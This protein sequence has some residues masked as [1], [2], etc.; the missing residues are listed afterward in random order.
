MSKKHTLAFLLAPVLIAC[1]AL[2]G[3]GGL[4]PKAEA[5]SGGAGTI[6][7]TAKDNASAVT[8]G[9]NRTQIANQISMAQ[10]TAEGAAPDVAAVVA[11]LKVVCPSGGA[12]SLDQA[13]GKVACSVHG[14]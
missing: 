2:A 13:T 1:L 4:K 8:C 7:N 12:Y 9:T 6:V 11:Q 5:E 3:C 10:S 14:E